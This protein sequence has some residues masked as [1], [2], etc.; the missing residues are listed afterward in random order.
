MTLRI[1]KIDQETDVLLAL[2]KQSGFNQKASSLKSHFGKL[3]R[4][5]DGLTY[6]KQ[7]R[8]GED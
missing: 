8:S 4:N 7:V 1:K 2:K 5:I 3:K 6:Q